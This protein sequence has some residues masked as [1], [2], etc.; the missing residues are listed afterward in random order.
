[1]STLSWSAAYL[2]TSVELCYMPNYNFYNERKYTY[3]KKPIENIILYNVKKTSKNNL[4]VLIMT[5]KDYQGRIKNIENLKINLLKIGLEVNIFYGVNGKN[6]K[7][8]DTEIEYMKI[9]NYN[10]E[11][12]FYNK[13]IRQGINGQTMKNGEFGC[14][15]SHLN[16]YKKLLCDDLYDNYLVLE[17]DA[18]LVTNLDILHE[19]FNNLP[20]K[21]DILHVAKSDWYPFILKEKINKYFYSIEKRFFNRLTAYIV[22]K[23]GALKLLM[24]SCGYILCS[25]HW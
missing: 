2:S 1:M 14:A 12:Y 7:I 25:K 10:D 15:I 5:V 19:I 22:S 20:E 21:F 13:N 18:E 6:I 8:I 3:F 16:I 11:T 17:D 9:L 23:S 24:Y 4:K